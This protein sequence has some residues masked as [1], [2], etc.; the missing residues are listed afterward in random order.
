MDSKGVGKWWKDDST[1][2]ETNKHKKIVVEDQRWRANDEQKDKQKEG[3][4]KRIVKATLHTSVEVHN[5][6]GF[7]NSSQAWN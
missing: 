5:L 4:K 6:Q 7:K 2:R 1:S 3:R